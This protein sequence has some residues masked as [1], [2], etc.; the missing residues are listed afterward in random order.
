M[1]R[2]FGSKPD[3]AVRATEGESRSFRRIQGGDA[4]KAAE[5]SAGESTPYQGSFGMTLRT[6]QGA[7][8]ELE[9]HPKGQ[10]EAGPLP[11][12]D[13]SMQATPIA[14]DEEQTRE[15]HAGITKNL[16]RRLFRP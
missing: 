9:K 8:F 16:F 1:E 11:S 6:T 13:S 2:R 14:A 12:S 7:K 15:A 3:P 10:G 5:E 4:A